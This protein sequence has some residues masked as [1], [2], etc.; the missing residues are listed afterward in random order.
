MMCQLMLKR[1]LNEIIAIRKSLQGERK[2]VRLTRSTGGKVAILPNN[3]M[4]VS[5]GP[6]D[7]RETIIQLMSGGHVAV[8]ED[9]EAVKKAI[10]WE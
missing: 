5:D 3:V 8:A 2:S 10:G 4:S 6:E 1:M 9:M 7:S